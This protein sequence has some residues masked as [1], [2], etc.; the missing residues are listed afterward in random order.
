ML[1]D[2][3]APAAGAALAPPLRTAITAPPGQLAI[4]TGLS[5]EARFAR[6]VAPGAI[7]LCGKADRDAIATRLPRTVTTILKLGLCGGLSPKLKIGD[8]VLAD[9]LIDGAGNTFHVDPFWLHA[10]W[11]A[12]RKIGPY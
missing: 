7:V 4:I 3:A 2:G 9:S 8:I 6:A 10:L 1:I 12:M 5:D 11:C